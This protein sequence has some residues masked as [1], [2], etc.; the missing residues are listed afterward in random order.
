VGLLVKTGLPTTK[1]RGNGKA[2]KADGWANAITGIGDKNRD[3]RR[4]TVFKQFGRFDHVQAEALYR[5]NGIARRI[6]DLPAKSMT[7][8]WFT[9]VGDEDERVTQRM[10]TLRAQAHVTQAVEWA[11]VYGGSIILMG[12]DDGQFTS[13]EDADLTKPVRE[14][15]I[16]A[17]NFLVPFAAWR[18]VQ[19]IEQSIDK[20][21]T[22]P[23][24]GKPTLYRITQLLGGTT[25]DVHVSRIIRFDGKLVPRFTQKANAGWHDSVY[26]S[27]FEQIRQVGNVFGNSEIITEDFVQTIIKV[28]DL[29]KQIATGQEA[30]VKTR[31]DLLD[32]S[33]HVL[34]MILLD[35]GEDYQ[36]QSSSVAGLALLLDRFVMVLSSVTGIPVTLLMG[37]SPS[38]LNA[39]GESDIRFW[40]DSVQADQ[41]TELKPRLE[42]LVQYLFTEGGNKAPDEWSIQF[43]PLFQ[44]TEKEKQ[45]IYK[46]TA[47]ADAIYVDR[48]VLDPNEVAVSRF[49]GTE[50]STGVVQLD[51]E[52][53][54]IEEPTDEPTE[55]D[56][57]EEPSE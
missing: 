13:E 2:R 12:I 48:G 20:D 47:E 32:L 37:R 16:K 23:T 21:A 31:M 36:R 56:P 52:T 10:E 19:V 7:R 46:G 42:K 34:N 44:M 27:T 45:E 40:Y 41:N 9:L 11:G 18:E 51:E 49:S 6:I 57:I 55:P 8:N 3:K 38:G 43:N 53:R 5:D 4:S 33:R 17:I 22:S 29:K 25:F 14:E 28:A 50:F 26:Q 35:E 1:D 39:T 24:F 30:L 15:S 54:G